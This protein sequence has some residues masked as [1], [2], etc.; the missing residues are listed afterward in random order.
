MSYYTIDGYYIQKK[1]SNKIIEKFALP[2]IKPMLNIFKNDLSKALD[3]SIDNTINSR[4]KNSI[5][6]KSF[7]KNN[8]SIEIFINDKN[9]IC[10]IKNNMMVC[11]NESSFENVN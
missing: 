6:I 11:I 7:D 10:A 5:P 1:K 3:K 2:N 9:E 8:K 4:L